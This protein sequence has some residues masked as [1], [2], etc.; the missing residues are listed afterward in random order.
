MKE[1]KEKLV[2]TNSTQKSLYGL[3]LNYFQELEWETVKFVHLKRNSGMTFT[4]E[5]IKYKAW[6]LT[7]SH[8][9]KRYYF[10]DSTG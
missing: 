7:E 6:E 2:N 5:P 3:K 9:I 4:Y 8:N 10:T 1:Q